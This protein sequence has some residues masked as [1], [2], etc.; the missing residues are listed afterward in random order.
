V[1]FAVTLQATTGTA[2]PDAVNGV[3]TR[4]QWLPQLG[5]FAYQPRARLEPPQATSVNV[6]FLAT[7]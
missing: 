6:Y 1:T 5:G 3:Y 7:E 4:W 2:P